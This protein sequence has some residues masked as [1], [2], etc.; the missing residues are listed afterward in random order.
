[1]INITDTERQGELIRIERK[2]QSLTQEQLTALAG[3]GVRFEHGLETCRI[4]LASAAYTL[5]GA[6][7]PGPRRL[8]TQS[9]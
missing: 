2:R 1:M 4:G 7:P 3:V 6:S 8:I 5:T 9:L